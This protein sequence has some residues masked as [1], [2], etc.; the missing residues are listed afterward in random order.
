MLCY[1]GSQKDSR[2]LLGPGPQASGW[3]CKLSV[4]PHLFEKGYISIEY[5]NPRISRK[6]DRDQNPCSASQ[7]ARV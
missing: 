6:I 4:I 2:T 3:L 7:K 5:S 1:S